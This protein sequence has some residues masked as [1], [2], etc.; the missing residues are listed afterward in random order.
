MTAPKF[1][2]YLDANRVRED[3][4]RM[5]PALR[6]K[7]FTFAVVQDGNELPE[8][9]L[10]YKVPRTDQIEFVRIGTADTLTPKDN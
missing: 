4:E 7:D 2:T 9:A 10:I 8:L 1:V 5:H 3:I 6:A